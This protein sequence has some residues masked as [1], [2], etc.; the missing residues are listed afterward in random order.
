MCFSLY[1]NFVGVEGCCGRKKIVERVSIGDNQPNSIQLNSPKP[2]RAK[3]RP[4]TVQARVHSTL[5]GSTGLVRWPLRLRRRI[6]QK[7]VDRS[8]EARWGDVGRGTW[9]WRRV[10]CLGNA[11]LSGTQLVPERD[12]AWYE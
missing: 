10:L 9:M 3:P 5:A 12:V 6:D 8:G 4:D 7:Q 1:L 2:S 11:I